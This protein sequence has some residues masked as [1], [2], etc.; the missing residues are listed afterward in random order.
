MN[1]AGSPERIKER[2]LRLAERDYVTMT[3]VTVALKITDITANKAI[4]RLS[5]EKLLVKTSV[6]S[7]RWHLTGSRWHRWDFDGTDNK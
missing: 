3:S 4:E 5:N 1:V 6:L 2:V 7:S